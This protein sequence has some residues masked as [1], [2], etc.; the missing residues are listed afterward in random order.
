M[1]V[2]R[3]LEEFYRLNDKDLSN[4]IL[5]TFKNLI[6]YYPLED[7]K[8]EI[9]L[10]LH[11]KKYIQNYRPLEITI[12][13]KNKTWEIKPTPAKFSTYICKFV[14]N[15]IF[16]Y[17]NKI[18]QDD[19]CLSL[20]N[21]NDSGFDKETNSKISYQLEDW[22][23]KDNLDLKL[24]ME[25][26]SKILEKKTKNRGSFACDKIEDTNLVKL[27]DKCGKEGCSEEEILKTISNGRI[28]NKENMTGLE[29][30]LASE[31]LGSIEKKDILKSKTEE[32][33]KKYF[34]SEP[35]RRSLYH[36]FNYYSNG[37]KDKEI[38][39]KFNMTVAGIGAMKRCLRKEIKRI[40][41]QK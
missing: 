20:D 17:Y 27:V 21:Y 31:V 10:R 1:K 13:S 7:L 33:I 25:K 23:P 22:N 15:Y 4:I 36:L 34:V 37:Y 12:D 9:Y 30:F 6:R 32:G 11:K 14:Y 39:Q 3:T 38:S 5:K 19:L 41:S 28:K 35:N 16:A 8:S 24:E 40:D 29:Q 2:T 18:K 26:V